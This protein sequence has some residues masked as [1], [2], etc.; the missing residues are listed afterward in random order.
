[1]REIRF[2]AWD[3]RERRMLDGNIKEG[4]DIGDGSA[5]GINKQIKWAQESD[6]ILMQYTGLKDKN[7]KEIFE[8][9]IYVPPDS[10][11]YR[12]IEFRDGCFTQKNSFPTWPIEINGEV[13]G[14]IYDNPDLLTT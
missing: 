12:V 7:G 11:I 9:D 13:I 2:R 4:R 6:F 5:R 3:N 10:S 8:G 1:M 14:N